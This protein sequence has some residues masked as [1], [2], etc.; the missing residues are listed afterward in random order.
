MREFDLLKHVYATVGSAGPS[1][2]IGPGDDMALVRLGDRQLLAAVDQIVDGRHVTV[3]TMPIELVGRKA[4]TRSLSDVAAMA[5]RPVALMAA[6][7]LPADFGHD[8]L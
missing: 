3:S 6:A 8:F 7:T 5:G 1:V 2:L 4:I